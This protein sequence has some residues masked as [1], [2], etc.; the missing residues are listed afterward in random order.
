MEVSTIVGKG[1]KTKETAFCERITSIK[2]KRL[3]SLPLLFLLLKCCNHIAIPELAS[4]LP[5]KNKEL[6]TQVECHGHGLSL[7]FKEFRSTGQLHLVR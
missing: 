6:R 4:E 3:H 5:L 2:K 7:S 1:A